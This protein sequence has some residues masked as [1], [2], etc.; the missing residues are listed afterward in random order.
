MRVKN[1]PISTHR[2]VKNR[3]KPSFWP[4]I[5]PFS[6][7]GMANL[8]FWV[9]S[10][11]LERFWPKTTDMAVFYI[12]MGRNMVVIESWSFFFGK[13]VKIR[14]N[15]IWGGHY[16]PPRFT[17]KFSKRCPTG[18]PGG[19]ITPVLCLKVANTNFRKSQAESACCYL[20][21]LN[22]GNS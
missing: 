14:E 1:N 19:Y 11:D 4:K 20:K 12:K 9:Q 7:D 17:E 16:V 21:I 3:Q 5:F 2:F 13:W 22:A 8:P 15:V 6:R 18:R 10:G